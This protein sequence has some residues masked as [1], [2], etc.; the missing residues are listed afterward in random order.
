MNSVGHRSRRADQNLRE[1][2]CD[3]NSKLPLWLCREDA[4]GFTPEDMK[5]PGFAIGCLLRIPVKR[6]DRRLESL[7]RLVDLSD[8]VLN[9]REQER[10]RWDKDILG[11]PL[12]QLQRVRIALGT[13]FRQR[14]CKLVVAEKP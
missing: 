14:L 5:H 9:H 12:Q 10:R 8:A 13:I 6:G 2:A 4:F 7:T 1:T 3:S 11:L